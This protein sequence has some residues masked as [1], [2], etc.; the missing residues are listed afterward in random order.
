MTNTLKT[1]AAIL[2]GSTLSLPA[3][4]G[5]MIDQWGDPV[6]DR[7]GEC[8]KVDYENHF[9]ACTPSAA[10]QASFKTASNTRAAEP[11]FNRQQKTLL[12]RAQFLSAGNPSRPKEAIA[13]P[14]KDS[15]PITHQAAEDKELPQMKIEQAHLLFETNEFRINEEHSLIIHQLMERASAMEIDYLIVQGYSDTRGYTGWNHELS[16]Y[17]TR[18]TLEFIR[19]KLTDPLTIL[20]YPLGETRYFSTTDPKQNRRVSIYL[21]GTCDPNIDLKGNCA[22]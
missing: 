9:E 15:T 3:Y 16:Q 8:V 14:A 5:Y 20:E 19:S 21:S 2:L 11:L 18:N 13:L 6:R 17:R 22:K 7:W 4:A 1:T 10:N 12:S